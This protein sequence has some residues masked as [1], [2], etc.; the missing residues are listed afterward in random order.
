MVDKHCCGFDSLSPTL[1]RNYEKEGEGQVKK[2][3]T[4]GLGREMVGW[5]VGCFEHC[6]L[7]AFLVMMDMDFV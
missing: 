1:F 7:N 6:S 5:E 4:R 3:L 2:S